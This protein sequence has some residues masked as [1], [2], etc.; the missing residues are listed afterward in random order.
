[1]EHHGSTTA[2]NQALKL[3][4]LLQPLSYRVDLTQ[5]Q[6]RSSG[7]V[8]CMDHVSDWVTASPASGRGR[9]LC[10]MAGA[11]EPVVMHLHP[12]LQSCPHSHLHSRP[13]PHPQPCPHPHPHELTTPPLGILSNVLLSNAQHIVPSPPPPTPPPPLP[14][15]T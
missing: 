1:M 3:Q 11:G 4:L 6:R 8:W 12:H 14:T 2:F 9:A 7:T 5:L 15:H 10:V 13:H